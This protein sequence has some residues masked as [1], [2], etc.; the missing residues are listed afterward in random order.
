MKLARIVSSSVLLAVVA[1]SACGDGDRSDSG[2]AADGSAGEVK[3]S[4]AARSEAEALFRSLCSTCHGTEGRGDG[5]GASEAIQPR[6]FADA[7][8]QASV[9]DER[10]RTV[11]TLGGA[12][13]GLNPAMPAQPQLKSKPEVLAALVDI[14]RGFGE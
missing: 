6:S 12:A 9:S 4:A 3:V 10:I 2:G 11:I 14:V 13:V 8:W 1:A 7:E 5:P